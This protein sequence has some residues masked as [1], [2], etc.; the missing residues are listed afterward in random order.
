MSSVKAYGVNHEQFT[1]DLE[2]GNFTVNTAMLTT[3]G[4][5]KGGSFA[6]EIKEGQPVQIYTSADM[7]VQLGASGTVIGFMDGPARGALPT[8]SLTSGNYTRRYGN[9]TLVGYRLIRVKLVAGN[10]TVS[11]GDSLAIDSTKLG[12]DKEED[13][14]SNVLAMEAASSSSGKYIWA[15]EKGTLA[16]EAD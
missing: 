4:I 12:F 9:I 6:A 2:E 8:S 7:T 16:N 14:T 13:T 15:L 10:A 1:F 3:K 5:A 11:V